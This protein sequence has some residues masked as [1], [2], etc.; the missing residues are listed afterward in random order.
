MPA[1]APF[2]DF[3]DVFTVRR[4]E[5]DEFYA[6]LQRGLDHEDA[7]VVQRQ[8]LA[9]MIWS[10]Q[11]YGYDVPRWLVGDPGQPPPP[12]QRENGRNREWLH[13]NNADVI[14]MPDTWE[15]PWY[16]AW[17]LAFHCLPLAQ[18]DAEFAK[19]QLVLLTRE[20]YMH[21]N[22]Q[23]PAYEWS[24][25]D[26]NPLVHAWATWRVFEVDRQQRGDAGDLIFLKRVFH[27]LLLNYTWWVNRKDSHQWNIFPTRISGVSCRWPTRSNCQIIIA[28]PVRV[29]EESAGDVSLAMK[30]AKH[31]NAVLDR[32]EEN[33]IITYREHRQ[34][35]REIKA[36][37]PHEGR[38]GS[39]CSVSLIRSSMRSA[40]AW[41]SWAM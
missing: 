1:P 23:L 15:Y 31:F 14:S 37:L 10:R 27:K 4:R 28:L 19:D 39:R 30:D 7:R 9:G 34:A 3:D 38:G 8:A 17:D 41:L 16:A 26:V 35:R 18:I 25:S 5:A 21:P 40:L 12:P 2:G 32:P 13:L 33:Q 11:Y 22:G 6:D 29:L 24:F 20:W 36:G